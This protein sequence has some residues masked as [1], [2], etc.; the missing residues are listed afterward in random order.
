MAR[1]GSTGTDSGVAEATLGVTVGEAVGP[2]GGVSVG[3][4]VRV[5]VGGSPSAEG[6][7]AI[8]A[9]GRANGVGVGTGAAEQA[10]DATKTGSTKAAK[11][12]RRSFITGTF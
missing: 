5:G 6:G 12:F 4:R 9:A 10:I 11:D 1:E 8:V 3:A 7:G 2:G